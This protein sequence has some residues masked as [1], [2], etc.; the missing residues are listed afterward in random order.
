MAL[1]VD[2]DELTADPPADDAVDCRAQACSEPHR[3]VCG[4]SRVAFTVLVTVLVG[5]VRGLV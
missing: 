4:T 1:S 5:K 2:D 3:S